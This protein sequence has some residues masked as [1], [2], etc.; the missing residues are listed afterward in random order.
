LLHS[1]AMRS[2]IFSIVFAVGSLSSLAARADDDA[3]EAEKP[4]DVTPSHADPAM[5][6]LPATASDTARLNAFGLQGARTRAARQAA[7]AAAA[8]AART[9]AAEHRPATAGSPSTHANARAGGVARASAGLDR[10]T[11]ASSGRAHTR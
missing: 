7:K 5:K 1:L 3:T 2:V 8:S 11:T 4:A 10:A 9:A 6:A